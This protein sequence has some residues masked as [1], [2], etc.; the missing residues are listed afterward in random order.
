MVPKSEPRFYYVGM[1]EQM[2]RPVIL[3]TEWGVKVSG[4]C[5]RMRLARVT[6]RRLIAIMTN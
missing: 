4:Q 3:G 6:P 5:N 1:N 2:L